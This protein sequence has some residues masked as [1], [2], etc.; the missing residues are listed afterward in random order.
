MLHSLSF[1]AV[2]NERWT[3]RQYGNVLSTVDIFGNTWHIIYVLS[4]ITNIRQ[5]FKLIRFAVFMLLISTKVE[6]FSVVEKKALLRL[7]F[8]YIENTT[9]SHT[10]RSSASATG[11]QRFLSTPKPLA[12]SSCVHPKSYEI[13]QK[14]DRRPW[15]NLC[16]INHNL[17]GDISELRHNLRLGDTASCT[18]TSPLFRG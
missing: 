15:R 7:S 1:Q 12:V 2:H 13:Q 6:S 4:S 18:C 5:N 16:L 8:V 11:S 3:R 9:E 17:V 14:W 10:F